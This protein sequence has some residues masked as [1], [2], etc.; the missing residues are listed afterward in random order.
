[1]LQ[2]I[3]DAG[4]WSMSERSFSSERDHRSVRPMVISS[5][6][7]PEIMTVPGVPKPPS[8]EKLEIDWH[9]RLACL[10]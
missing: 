4:S 8:S 7:H 1:M 3:N 5:A 2:R 10:P 6:V 9:V